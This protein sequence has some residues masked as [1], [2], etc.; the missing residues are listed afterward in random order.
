MYS[1]LE[2]VL[3]TALRSKLILHE[4]RENLEKKNELLIKRFN[5]DMANLITPFRKT[6]S[7]SFNSSSNTNIHVLIN[8]CVLS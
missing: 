8:F 4:F 1:R 3:I 5:A 2:L 7:I 6:L